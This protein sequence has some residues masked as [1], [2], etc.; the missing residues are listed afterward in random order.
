[1]HDAPSNDFLKNIVI[2]FVCLSLTLSCD[3]SYRVNVRYAVKIWNLGIWVRSHGQ[4]SCNV[5]MY[6]CTG[7]PCYLAPTLFVPN[8]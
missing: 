4:M 3:S 6:M 5:Y 8:E 7:V 2:M 1:M